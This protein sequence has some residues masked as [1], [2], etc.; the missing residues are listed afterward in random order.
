MEHWQYAGGLMMFQGSGSCQSPGL[1]PTC[2]AKVGQVAVGLA[3]ISNLPPPS[4]KHDAS[5][6]A[7]ACVQSSSNF[8]KAA[9]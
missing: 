5:R 8:E 7:R 2:L 4:P 9:P 1:L 3:Q 6:R